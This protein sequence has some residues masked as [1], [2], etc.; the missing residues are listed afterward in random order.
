MYK[1][2]HKTDGEKIT[3]LNS[4]AEFIHFI[5]N[6]A[7]ENEDE[8]MSITTL[9]EAMDYLKEYCDNLAL[10]EEEKIKTFL[11]TYGIEVEENEPSSYVE[12]MMDNHKCI[13]LENKQYYIPE[14]KAYTTEEDEIYDLLTYFQVK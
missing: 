5:R 11:D 3:Q 9:G 2:L 1:I 7:V 10:I 12:L 13:V 4:D 6:I 8:D 14:D